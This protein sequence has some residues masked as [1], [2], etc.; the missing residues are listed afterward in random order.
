MVGQTISH[1][2]I[3]E[4]LGGAEAL[5]SRRVGKTRLFQSWGSDRF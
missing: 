3:L 4:K 5:F 1:Y 2:N